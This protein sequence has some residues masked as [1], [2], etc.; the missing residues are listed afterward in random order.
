MF[1]NIEKAIRKCYSLVIEEERYGSGLLIGMN[2]LYPNNELITDLIDKATSPGDVDAIEAL[3]KLANFSEKH[4]EFL[5][6]QSE[7]LSKGLEE[8]DK[9]ALLWNQLSS[10][11]RETICEELSESFN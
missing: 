8:L 10:D 6:V 4:S 2:F 5:F 1:E 11:K 7:T 3:D 9:K